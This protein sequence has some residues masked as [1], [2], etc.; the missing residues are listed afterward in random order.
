MGLERDKQ[1]PDCPTIIR[2]L[3]DRLTGDAVGPFIALR[4]DRDSGLMVEVPMP[5]EG[6]NR[7]KDETDDEI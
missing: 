6:S 1:N 7:F 5:D 3:K 4:Y 2:G